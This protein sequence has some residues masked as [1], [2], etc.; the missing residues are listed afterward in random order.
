MAIKREVKQGTLKQGVDEEI[1]YKVV[2]TPWGGTPASV[3]VVVK[4]TSNGN[5]VVTGLVMPAGTASVVD[6]DITLP[7]LKNLVIGHKYRVEVKFSSSGNTF[8]P[9][10]Y[11]TAEL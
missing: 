6:D 8:E 10:F 9:Y 4:D 11:V 3:S 5:N 1:A 7:L 2:T